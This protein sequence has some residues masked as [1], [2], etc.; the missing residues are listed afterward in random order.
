MIDPQFKRS[1]KD[2]G[3]HAF[4]VLLRRLRQPLLV[5]IWVYAVSVLGFTLVPG[6]DP[7]GRTWRMSFL[8]AF[9]FV[10]FLGTTIGLGEIPYPFSE[11]QRL[12]ATA[13]IYGTVVAWLYGIG[14][15][16]SVLQDPL[17]RRILHEKSAEMGVKRLKEPFIILCGYDDA[18]YRVCRELTESGSRIVVVDIDQTKVDRVDVDEHTVPVPALTGDASDPRI[19]EIAGLCDPFCS[20]ILALTGSDQVNTKIGLTARL[21]NPGVPVLCAARDHGWHQHMAVAGVDHIINPFDTFAERIGISLR[22]PSLHVIYEALTTQSGTAMTKVPQLPRNRWVLC[23]H[24]LF[25]R[26]L[27]RQLDAEGIATTLV[28]KSPPPQSWEGEEHRDIAGAPTDPSVLKEAIQEDV[29]ALVAGTKVDIDNLA[30]V[31]AA[32]PHRKR[33]FVVARQ[34][35]RR[36]AN[37]FKASGADLVVLSGYVIAA[38]VLRQLRAPLL[39][40]FLRRAQ[41]ESE[42]WATDLLDRL[43][44]TVGENVLESWTVKVD[45]ASTPQLFQALRAGHALS[46]GRLLTNAD[47]NDERIRAVP[48]FLLRES[49]KGRQKILLPGDDVALSTGDKVLVCGSHASRVRMQAALLG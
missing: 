48:L 24:D 1:A 42:A 33:L 27:R 23:G 11:A 20:G 8:Q 34:E 4:F 18:G 10:S 25:T 47:S 31:L 3:G 19:L 13:S 15:L 40:M 2:V 30:I 12:W 6:V 35:Q 39:S 9:Y 28:D 7:E 16:F 21:L 17:F 5:L 26:A 43:R 44:T 14:A 49:P 29:G 37:V 45:A 36:N 32:S 22:T 41:D 38:E 46:V